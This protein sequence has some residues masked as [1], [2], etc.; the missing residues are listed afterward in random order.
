MV[1]RYSPGLKQN[2]VASAVTNKCFKEKSCEKQA[3]IKKAAG[4]SKSSY[5]VNLRWKWIL[6]SYPVGESGVFSAEAIFIWT[7]GGSA[8]NDDEIQAK[9]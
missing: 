4:K 7:T 2:Q 5:V 3:S 8:D 6:Y 1:R 9:K